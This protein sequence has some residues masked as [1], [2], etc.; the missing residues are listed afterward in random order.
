MQARDQARTTAG[1]GVT[2]EQQA[3]ASVRRLALGQ[4]AAGRAVEQCELCSLHL[5][6]RHRH[7][8][9][10]ATRQILCACDACALTFDGAVGARFKAIPRDVFSLEDLALSD[11]AWESLGLPINLA[12]ILQRT[13][14][15]NRVAMYPSP[16][17]VT[18]ALITREAWETL[19]GPHPFPGQIAPDVQALLVNRLASRRE[20]YIAP[21]DRCFELAGVIRTHWRGFSGGDAVWRETDSFFAQ[22]RTEA[23]PAAREAVHA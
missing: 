15:D 14:Q 7:L 11:G 10:L 5:A 1:W 3:F 8:V 6:P 21:I 23:R 12:F 13:G 4:Q 18:E 19:A 17:G 22:L 9:E 20:Y 2:G 16:A